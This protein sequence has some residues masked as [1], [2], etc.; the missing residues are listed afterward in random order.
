[1]RLARNLANNPLDA[2]DM[3]TIPSVDGMIQLSD[4]LQVVMSRSYPSGCAS[5]MGYFTHFENNHR[6]FMQVDY[7]HN[8]QAS[9]WLT[10]ISLGHHQI[11][12]RCSGARH[13]GLPGLISKAS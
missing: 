5:A 8:N 9:L 12:A 1:L 3:D 4:L 11:T 6:Q 10:P 7:S 13:S 2:P